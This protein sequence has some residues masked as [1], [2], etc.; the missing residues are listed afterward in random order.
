MWQPFA[1]PSAGLSSRARRRREFPH[2]R[3]DEVHRNVRP[4]ERTT[5]AGAAVIARGDHLE[6]LERL[7]QIPPLD[8]RPTLERAA[9]VIVAAFGADKVDAMLLEAETATLVAVGT[10]DT[11]MGRKERA[12]GLDRMPIANGGRAAQVFE[13]GVPH[14]SGRVDQD[15]GQLKG[16][17]D[18]LGIRSE[19][20]APLEVSGQRRGVVL[21]SSAKPDAFSEEDLEFL[22]TVSRWVGLV[23]HRVD[24]TQRVTEQAAEQA[25]RLSADE[26]VT[27][28]AHDLRNHLAAAKG[29]IQLVR[30]WW[31]CEDRPRDLTL[32]EDAATAIDRI[33]R[34]IEDL[35]D[36]SRLERGAFAITPRRVDLEELVQNTV[37]TFATAP[38]AVQVDIQQA[39]RVWADSGRVSQALENLLANAVR[40]APEGTPVVVTVAA[41]AR[42]DGQWG[43]LAVANQGPDVPPE[44]RARLFTR[45]SAGTGSFGLGL[46]LYIAS[47]IAAAHGGEL[48]V[49]SEP[50]QGACFQLSLPVDGPPA[51][52][53]EGARPRL[54][55]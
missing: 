39:V 44:V 49:S 51:T 28:L 53:T 20:I 16:L 32:V 45:F 36:V 29:R 35:L 17:I 50:G 26:L 55:E 40:H 12:L 1:A 34:I 19:I 23:A 54:G 33:Q 43:L 7:L 46:G 22:V 18:G 4:R 13:T 2:A 15:P 30:R 21:A 38:R 14:R 37:T 11:P 48:S 9:D 6:T 25:R 8:L 27:I 41:E 31:T 52:G 10:S 47:R 42:P 3:A 5:D 24:L